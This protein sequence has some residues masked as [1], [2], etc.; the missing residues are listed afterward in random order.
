MSNYQEH[1]YPFDSYVYEDLIKQNY[2]DL[3]PTIQR[4]SD[5][6]QH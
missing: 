3:F 6:N 2:V 4:M 5:T 1:P